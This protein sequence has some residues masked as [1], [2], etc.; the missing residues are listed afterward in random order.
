[1]YVPTKY[2]IKLKKRNEIRVANGYLKCIDRLLYKI[3]YVENYE[4][5]DMW[6]YGVRNLCVKNSIPLTFNSEWVNANSESF[7]DDGLAELNKGLPE[8]P[9]MDI[10]DYLRAIGEL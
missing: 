8:E 10:Q 6:K 4:P 7:E 5:N 3:Y 9:E 2:Y 1:M